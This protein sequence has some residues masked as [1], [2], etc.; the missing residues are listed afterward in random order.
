MGQILD[1]RQILRAPDADAIAAKLNL[2]LA[3]A[4]LAR[5]R[6]QRTVAAYVNHGR[7]VADCPECRGGI[8]CWDQLPSGTCPDCGGEYEVKWPAPEVRAAAEAVLL[9]RA[10][11]WHRNWWPGTETVGWLR[12]ENELLEGVL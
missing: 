12:T 9:G 10:K 4:G 11:R 5:R 7:W 1:A 8:A 2:I 3:D 6:D